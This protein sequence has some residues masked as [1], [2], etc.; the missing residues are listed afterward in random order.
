MSEAALIGRNLSASV[1]AQLITQLL[2][3]V[4]SIVLARTL[5]IE[6]YGIFAFGIAFPSWFL[7]TVSLGLD[8][9]LTI[10]VA[11]DRAKASSHVAIVALVRL[12]FAVLAILFLWVAVQFLL[13]DPLARTVTVL[14]GIAG[15]LQ[16]YA[17]TFT[18]VFRAFERLE[19][20]AL[21][22]VVE[23][24]ATTGITLLLLVLGY[25]LLGVALVFVA[26]GVLAL[27]L[28]LVLVR[29]RFVS[30]TSK[31]ERGETRKVLR[32]AVPFALM[33]AV[34]TFTAST[35]VVLLTVLLGPV[36]TGQ[37]NAAQTL[38]F[39]LLS[40]FTIYSFV[41]LPTLSRMSREA[42]HKIPVVIQKA[43]KLAFVFGLP[44]ALG[45]W[46]Y[47]E[48]IVTLIYGEAFL[49]SARSFEILVFALV[50]STAVL[51]YGT[52]LAATG[53]QTVNLYI[54]IATGVTTVGLTVALIPSLGQVGA[55]YAVLVGIS[56]GAILQFVAVRR[57]VAHIDLWPTFNRTIL[58]GAAM[59]L[60]LLALPVSLWLGIVLGVG[61]Y[62]PI[63][64][65]TR[66]ITREDWDI[67]KN[68]LR[69]ALFRSR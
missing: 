2:T 27:V 68:A 13:A 42:V 26:G 52:A 43:Q 44:L 15:V 32:L 57:L 7:L 12:P 8:S 6:Q 34:T 50:A 40:I 64:F 9:V 46:L 28:S 39:A 38:F 17:G 35:G 65:I 45:G 16:T 69:G 31:V 56:L 20:D 48:E 59:L 18:S 54:G 41:A 49:E 63:L 67:M 23:R 53:R 25:G 1:T 36:V 37:F 30:F 24:V 3:F 14:L 62:F 51:G 4:V 66:G 47:A 61:I 21:V 29:R 11:G 33:A 60:V 58:A 55:A 5:G 10:E 19:F 22:L